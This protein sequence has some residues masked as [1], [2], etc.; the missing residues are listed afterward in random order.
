MVDQAF[1][2]LVNRFLNFQAF[3]MLALEN[4]HPDIDTSRSGVL[5]NYILWP[6]KSLFAYSTRPTAWSAPYR[7]IALDVY[8]RLNTAIAHKDNVSI[9]LLSRDPYRKSIPPLVGGGHSYNWKLHKEVTPAR[10]MS[11]RAVQGHFS[12]KEEPKSR[13]VVEMVVRFDTEQSMEIYAKDGR[14]LHEIDPD[15]PRQGKQIPAKRQRVIEYLI[16]HKRLWDPE[17]WMVKD[18]LW[19]L[20]GYKVLK[21]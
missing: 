12:T 11:I 4:V 15:T 8:T 19:P 2:N 13:N 3:Y 21:S 9:A 10:L 5:D 1:I 20:V 14:P 18:Q 7:K 6:W 17:G 16:I